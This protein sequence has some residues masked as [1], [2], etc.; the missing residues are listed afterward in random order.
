MHGLKRATDEIEEAL[1]IVCEAHYLALGQV[2]IANASDN[3]VPF[4]DDTQRKQMFVVRLSGY[5]VD[6]DDYDLDDDP[7]KDYDDMCYVFPLKIGEG[8][9]GKTLQTYEPHF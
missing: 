9:P 2:W 3:R 1:K 7:I 4:L 8:L 5:G 6:S